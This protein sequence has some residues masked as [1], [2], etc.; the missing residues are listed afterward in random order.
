[1]QHRPTEL[2]DSGAQTRSQVVA[3]AQNQKATGAGKV[4][5]EEIARLTFAAIRE[6]RFYIYSHPQAMNAV[7]DR[8]EA[9]IEQRNPPDPYAG[10][11]ELRA[12]LIDSLHG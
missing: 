12:R 7:R 2:A 5:A 9:I 10:F 3:Q 8:F 1:A 6:R 4:S 11:P